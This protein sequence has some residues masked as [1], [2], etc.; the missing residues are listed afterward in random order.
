MAHLHGYDVSSIGNMLNHY[1]RHWADPNQDK[2]RYRNQNIDKTRTH[3][4]YAIA[5]REH[6]RAFIQEVMDSVDTPVRCGKKATNVIS[7]I[8]VTLPRNERLE[9][10]EHEFFHAAYDALAAKV[11]PGNIVGA[12]VHL[13]ETTPHMHFCFV[14]L[15]ETPK[16]ENDKSRPMLDKHG[17][18]KKDS[19]GTPR[20]E[21]KPVLDAQG[22]PVMRR[23][24]SQAKMFDRRA[25]RELHPYLEAQ[26]Q[27][28]FGFKVGMMLDDPGDKQLSHLDHE[29]YKQARATLERA[30]VD[31]LTARADEAAARD[32]LAKT[33]AS[34]GAAKNELQESQ[35]M[36][37]ALRSE[38]A[39]LH[40]RKAEAQAQVGEYTAA[41]AAERERLECLR[42]ARSGAE[43]RVADLERSCA[44][45]RAEAAA[46]PAVQSIGASL[47]TLAEGRGDGSREKQ[48]GSE[49][50]RLRERISGA[51]ERVRGLRER[52]EQLRSAVEELR[53]KVGAALRAGVRAIVP[54]EWAARLVQYMGRHGIEGRA[55]SEEAR[56]MLVTGEEARAAGVSLADEAK[57]ARAVR[58]SWDRT[59]TPA[60]DRARGRGHGR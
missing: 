25:L 24:L 52:A 34:V 58:R 27:K 26:M 47:E 35:G 6:P 8:I 3:F 32:E 11:G 12:W 33:R 54:S 42:R 4:N 50:E 5:A 16:M 22:Q 46:Q 40:E 43:K 18:Q 57:H 7:D 10:R 51:D 14:P 30:E 1:T 29:G 15:V 41:A 31:A 48:L 19:K 2:Y 53:A 21:R 38:V 36:A 55:V 39:E 9:G 23:S 56:A 37:A 44:A 13:D 60:Q 59:H 28:H 49:I 17:V 20:W 45:A